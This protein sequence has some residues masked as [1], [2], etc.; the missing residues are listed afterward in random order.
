MDKIGQL[1]CELDAQGCVVRANSA[2]LR[3]KGWGAQDARGRSFAEVLTGAEF[4]PRTACMFEENLQSARLGLSGGDAGFL[5]L[6]L[7]CE[8]GEKVAS[9]WYFRPFARGDDGR[10]LALGWVD[11]VNE[12]LERF[13]LRRSRITELI[14]ESVVITNASGIVEY[15]NPAFCEISGYGP[16]EVIGGS[17][18]RWINL[19]DDFTVLQKVLRSL[20]SGERWEGL[21]HLRTSE[22]ASVA[23]N[24]RI[25]PFAGEADGNTHY[26]AI[27]TDLTRERG[28]EKQ[29]EELQR[30]ESLG[31]LA[32]GIAHRFNNLLASISGQ[33]E[34]LMMMHPDNAVISA[35]GKKILDAIGKGR[36]FVNQLS[37]FSRKEKPTM[38]RCDL[39]RIARHAINFIRSVLPRGIELVAEIPENGPYVMGNSDEIH[40]VIINLCSN[41]LKAMEERGGFL[42]IRLTEQFR[43]LN[44]DAPDDSRQPVAVIAVADSGEGIPENIRHRIFEP[45][46]TTRN[47]A[48]SSGMGLAVAHG[49]AQRHG[50]NLSFESEPGKGTRFEWLLPSLRMEADAPSAA[51]RPDVTRI[52]PSSQSPSETAS[53][54]QGQPAHHPHIFLVED[55][56]FAREAGQSLLQEAGYRVTALASFN[57]ALLAVEENPDSCDLLLTDLS[58]GERSGLDLIAF[59]RNLAPSLPVVL[60]PSMHEHIDKEQVKLLRVQSVLPKPCPV[61]KLLDTIASLL[62]QPMDR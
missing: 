14:S 26:I 3:L 23:L 61:D 19:P 16:G 40:Q 31:T 18:T 47:M 48:E 34:L 55:E 29:V 46:F 56:R 33:A 53:V 32:N 43:E 15:V 2:F 58:L 49:I 44:P 28:L 5:A 12:P 4:D 17:P 24:T 42:Q 9:H 21:L 59:V 38:R 7:N 10:F 54:P 35:Q 39:A 45:F 62:P 11:H 22:G 52:A 8:G 20:R 57:E 50:G 1:A 27:S 51:G 30:L 13:L 36:D 37:S 60:L 6:P 25:C 41:A